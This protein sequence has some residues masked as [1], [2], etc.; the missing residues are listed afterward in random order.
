MSVID[1]LSNDSSH[2]HSDFTLID[3]IHHTSIWDSIDWSCAFER[4]SLSCI[5]S[6]LLCK[7]STVSWKAGQHTPNGLLWNLSS[8]MKWCTLCWRSRAIRFSD[9]FFKSVSAALTF[10]W[11]SSSLCFAAFKW[12]EEKWICVFL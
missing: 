12:K 7:A 11:S 3:K 2:W 6:F 5:S 9:D 8:N 4:A 10:D 1:Q